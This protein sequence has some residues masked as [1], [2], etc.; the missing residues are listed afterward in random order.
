MSRISFVPV[1]EWTDE[2]KH[3]TAADSATELER[4]ITRMLAH[5]PGAAMGPIS[6]G[7]ALVKKPDATR[8]A[9]RTAQAARCFSQSMPQLHGHP[10]SCRAQ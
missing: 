7:A 9:H 4:G 5:A 3:V 10:V 6:F 1:S 2:L 8:T